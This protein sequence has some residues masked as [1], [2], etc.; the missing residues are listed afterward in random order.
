M[1]A[2]GP[3][4]ALT[5]GAQM[6][7]GGSGGPVRARSFGIGVGRLSSIDYQQNIVRTFVIFDRLKG[8]T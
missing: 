3:Y 2:R 6:V 7:K 1:L 4:V 8:L 5:L